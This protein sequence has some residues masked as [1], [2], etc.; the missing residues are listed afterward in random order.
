MLADTLFFLRVASTEVKE[1]LELVRGACI[2]LRVSLLF[3][4]GLKPFWGLDKAEDVPD[5][6]AQRPICGRSHIN[7]QGMRRRDR[8]PRA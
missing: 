5:T 4:S 1:V 7:Y 2:Y 6:V 3:F 8:D